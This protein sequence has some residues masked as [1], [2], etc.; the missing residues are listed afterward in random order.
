MTPGGE[1]GKNDAFLNAYNKTMEHEG[2]YSNYRIDPGGETYK[3][4]SRVYWPDWEGWPIIDKAKKN[5]KPLERLIELPT[6]T[7]A[8]YR[9]NFWNRF[10]GFD[11]ASLSVPVAEE[12]FDTSVNLGAHKAVSYLQDSLN[13]LNDDQRV[14][15]DMVIDGLLGPVT[16]KNLKLFMNRRL[17]PA[18]DKERMLLN[19]MNVL[20]GA[21]YVGQMRAH[22]EKEKFRGW[23]LRL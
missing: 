19:L 3:G 16:L 10:R 1:Q 13:L 15:P 8:F 23:F 11:I 4:I 14:Y 22:P 21:H 7:K 17:L 20:Q 2:T 12:L 9:R 5:G 6:M 18:K